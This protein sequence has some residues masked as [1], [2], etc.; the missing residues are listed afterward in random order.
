MSVTDPFATGA[1]A[2]PAPGMDGPYTR[3]FAVTP[4]NS[5]DFAAVTR[6]LFIGG[7][8]VVV[9]VTDDDV[10]V[11]YTVPAGF[12][13]PGRFRRVNSTNTTATLMVGLY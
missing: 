2:P 5:S 12:I 10:A 11:N 4:S 1:M 6:G 3:H 13:L 9:A 8:G 7:A